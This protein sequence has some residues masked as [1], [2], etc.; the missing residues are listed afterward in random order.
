MFA[1]LAVH[2][3]VQEDSFHLV[4]N[5]PTQKNKGQRR[6]NP[7]RF[8]HRNTQFNRGQPEQ[9]HQ[10][11]QKQQK[12]RQFQNFHRDNQRV[13]HP[14]DLHTCQQSSTTCSMLQTLCYSCT[15]TCCLSLLSPSQI[16]PCQPHAATAAVDREANAPACYQSS[17]AQ[18]VMHQKRTPGVDSAETGL[19]IAPPYRLVCNRVLQRMSYLK[20]TS[21]SELVLHQMSHAN[22]LQQIR[23]SSAVKLTDFLHCSKSHTAVQWTSG[24]NGQLWSPF[25][26]PPWPSSTSLLANQRT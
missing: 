21:C 14:L 4:D 19:C 1:L 25:P 8:A 17:S 22:M 26:S 9:P 23:D 15:L 24:Q 20:R 12:Q 11:R 13:T 18:Q 3:P 10:A 5:R 6:F 2:L 16:C 7:Q